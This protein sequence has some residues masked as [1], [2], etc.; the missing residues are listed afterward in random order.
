M[1]KESVKDSVRVGMLNPLRPRTGPL[2]LWFQT[3][4]VRVR[5]GIQAAELA[6]L[7]GA[8]FRAHHFCQVHDFG[9][10][11]LPLSLVSLTEKWDHLSLQDPEGSERNF[12]SFSSLKPSI[13]LWETN[14]LFIP[15]HCL[16]NYENYRSVS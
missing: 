16:I 14:Q 8:G 4:R 6:R 7:G 1:S 10:C 15:N 12:G 9:N 13:L 11:R 2:L 5:K 3:C